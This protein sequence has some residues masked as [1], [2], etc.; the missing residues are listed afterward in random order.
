M[1]K[2]TILTALLALV[3]LAGQGQVH[4][5]QERNIVDSTIT[6]KAVVRVMYIQLENILSIDNQ[7]LIH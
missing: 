1:N 3:T 7:Q 6:G 5:Q 4:Y 2:Q